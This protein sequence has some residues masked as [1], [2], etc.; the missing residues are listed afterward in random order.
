MAQQQPGLALELGTF[1]GYGTMRIWRQLPPGGRVLSIEAG[2]EQ[3]G[4]WGRGAGRLL[5]RLLGAAVPKGGRWPLVSLHLCTAAFTA[6][7]PTCP[8][9]QAAVAQQVL[10]LAGVPVGSGPEARVQVVNGLSGDVLPRLRQLAGL[11]EAAEG[12]PGAADFVFL[13]HCKPV[14]G[15]AHPRVLKAATCIR[16]NVPAAS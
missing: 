15:G 14:R 10:E 8:C 4:R 7:L 9:P 2:E 6:A 1:M 5:A 13:D 12:K 11:P 3:V 16:R